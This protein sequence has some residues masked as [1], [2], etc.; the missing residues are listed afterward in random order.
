[1]RLG[2][3]VFARARASVCAR[4]TV[5]LAP[6]VT[7][8]DGLPAQ[9]AGTLLAMA[10][11]PAS[12]T[13]EQWANRLRLLLSP[14]DSINADGSVKQEFYKPKKIVF[15]VDKKWGEAEKLKLYEASPRR[16]LLPYPV[17]AQRRSRT[18]QGLEKYGVGAWKE[19]RAAL[20]PEV[21]SRHPPP[22]FAACRG[23]VLTSARRF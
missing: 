5:R 19:M 15:V 22:L 13:R 17:A 18:A 4:A 9:P 14:K 6:V 11:G 23:C 12:E 1:M 20:L 2:R 7:P 16:A 8:S 10:A 3:F 21:R